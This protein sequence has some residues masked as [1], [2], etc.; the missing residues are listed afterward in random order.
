MS[1]T[2]GGPL[3]YAWA[4]RPSVA[5]VFAVATVGTGG[6]GKAADRHDGALEG[7]SIAGG[8]CMT[9]ETGCPTESALRRLLQRALPQSR[10]RQVAAHLERCATCRDRLERLA[11]S[12]VVPPPAKMSPED[13][14]K[15]DEVIRDL[16]QGFAEP[17]EPPPEE[18]DAQEETSGE[19]LG[20]LTPDPQG[21]SL[22]FLEHYRID[23]ILGRG[24]MGVVFGGVDLKL[25][26]PVAIKMLSAN[27]GV[28]D[29]F[30]KRFVREARA[31]AS[32]NHPN[33][34]TVYA[35]SEVNHL[36]YMVME[37]V[38]G[39][40]LRDL[41]IRRGPLTLDEIL[42]YSL[43][44]A[45]GLQAAH[46]RGVIHRDVKP[47]NI[48]IERATRRPKLADFGLA[49]PE[50]GPSL[51][52]SGAVMGT[53]EYMS[54]E[55][56]MGDRVDERSDLYS[57]GRLM[58]VMAGG[59]PRRQAQDTSDLVSE[60]L[61]GRWLAREENFRFIPQTL[62]PIIRKLLQPDPARR[63]QSAE[64]V[65]HALLAVR[66]QGTDTPATFESPTMCP[67]PLVD[68]V[69][70]TSAERFS[71]ADE[72]TATQGSG[73]RRATDAKHRATAASAV[74]TH[75][76][77]GTR[78]GG[79]RIVVTAAVVAVAMLA[80]SLMA[81]RSFF[82]SGRGTRDGAARSGRV[83]ESD[84]P[85]P[86]RRSADAGADGPEAGS[87]AAGASAS[88]VVAGRFVRIL[89]NGGREVFDDFERAVA[90][91]SAGD[92]LQVD[93]DGP[94][95]VPPVVF[96]QA[97]TLQGAPGAQ[98]VLRWQQLGER[99]G[100][101]DGHAPAGASEASAG[102]RAGALITVRAPLVIGNLRIEGPRGGGLP[103][104]AALIQVDGGELS[105][106][107]CLL[108]AGA[109]DR[110]AACLVVDNAAKVEIKR[111]WLN[112]G[113]G[114][115]D[116][117]PLGG[118]LRCYN[119]LITAP[120]AVQLHTIGTTDRRVLT[121]AQCTVLGE[122]AF[123][124]R[125]DVGSVAEFGGEAPVRIDMNGCILAARR[126]LW[127]QHLASEDAV[128]PLALSWVQRVVRLSCRTCVLFSGDG[129][130][131]EVD[132]RG[133]TIRVGVP[134]LQ[135]WE[136]FW[137]VDDG[138]NV[139]LRWAPVMLDQ[140][141]LSRMS[142]DRVY[143]LL[144]RTILPVIRRNRIVAGAFLSEIPGFAELAEFGD[145]DGPPRE[146]PNEPPE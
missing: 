40:T 115:V 77:G 30:R 98:P 64:D 53:P 21:S 140:L 41:L 133:E 107:D 89:R 37:F 63:F 104:D 61:D 12:E 43:Q 99:G 95:A 62:V 94:I 124:L 29:A 136:V 10:E 118:V 16:K 138:D 38:D 66:T 69:A 68:A 114:L 56:A 113:V 91:L 20:F 139:E 100:V 80:A 146:G 6:H 71:L 119:V 58:Y 57:L 123:E 11:G 137:S 15:L 48:L 116:W 26:R 55:Q 130:V 33:V 73:D 86:M 96:D 142:A 50:Q 112:G 129:F 51:T 49:R 120:V 4:T 70:G 127:V 24:G 82:A 90:A 22:G 25:H 108:D 121:L 122:D 65:V 101:G 83:A 54:P 60:L 44:I 78:R 79:R 134:R 143:T 125:A 23:S 105:I 93:G 88:P 117:N 72:D 102:R 141:D 39:G 106:E 45:R 97:V 1:R 92:V 67:A 36:P 75:A 59:R 8:V 111:C 5:A 103:D 17:S 27:L 47:S 14:R 3:Y 35:V 31:V 2:D 131:R 85:Q 145:G 34:V 109:A 74:R 28:S 76:E 128:G 7:D 84:T 135:A 52:L 46:S 13:R 42:F 18:F 32:I 81:L 144:R 110:R 9:V 132:A 19:E 126:S 87:M